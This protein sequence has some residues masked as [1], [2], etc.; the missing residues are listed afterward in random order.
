M[1]C[2]VLLI[3]LFISRISSAVYQVVFKTVKNSI[4]PRL[5]I[6]SLLV[7]VIKV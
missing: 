1:Y 3:Q 5:V 2:E 4:E 7:I 6:S